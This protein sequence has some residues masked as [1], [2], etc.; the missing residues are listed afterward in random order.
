MENSWRAAQHEEPYRRAALGVL[1]NLAAVVIYHRL[2]II[3]LYRRRQHRGGSL[4]RST[5]LFRCVWP[6]LRA[7][8]HTHEHGTDLANGL[9]LCGFH[10]RLME[11]GWDIRF[12]DDGI[13]WFIPPATLDP[14]RFRHDL[15]LA[16]LV[17]ANFATVTG[18]AIKKSVAGYDHQAQVESVRKLI[19]RVI[20]LKDWE[21]SV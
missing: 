13:P 9:P 17:I 19:E 4:D 18:D 7:K 6:P 1:R 14:A 16:S 15:A 20:A 21:A 11:E 5:R 12:D 2:L 3:L 10:N 8:R